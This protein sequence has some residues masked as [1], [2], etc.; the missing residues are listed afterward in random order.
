MLF[1][2]VIGKCSY[3]CTNLKLYL[4]S[5]MFLYYLRANKKHTALYQPHQLFF[6][7]KLFPQTRRTLVRARCSPATTPRWCAAPFAPRSA[8][9]RRRRSTDRSSSTPSPATCSAPSPPTRTSCKTSGRLLVLW[10]LFDAVYFKAVLRL[11]SRIYEKY[12]EY[13]CLFNVVSLIFLFVL[14]FLPFFTC[15][16]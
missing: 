14:K 10:C 12:I 9:S 5:F 4:T 7:L 2:C 11:D 8:S 3:W 1:L 13:V 15:A 6:S 16:N